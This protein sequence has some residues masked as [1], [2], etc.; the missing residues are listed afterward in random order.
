MPPENPLPIV[1]IYDHTDGCGVDLAWLA[2]M[3][4]R[5][6]PEC[7][8]VPGTEAPLLP[9]LEL[10]EVSLISDK[11]IA[12]VHGEFMD[13]PTATD[14]MTFHHGEILISADTA[15]REGPRHGHTAAAETLLYLIH[16]LLHLNGH[17]DS[18]EPERGRMH[19]CQE[20][21]L[22]QLLVG[23]LAE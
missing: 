14:V 10:V 20:K 2:E 12:K 1:E 11:E 19:D 17:I 21:I 13:D 22:K 6:L 23:D 5:A 7:L 4:S 18:A 15:K 9:G 8:R 16:G 3:A